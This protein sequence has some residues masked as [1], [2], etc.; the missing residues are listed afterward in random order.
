[1]FKNAQNTYIAGGSFSV[2]TH[3][4][5]VSTVNGPSLGALYKRVAPQAILNAGGRADEVRCHP[6]TRKEVIGRIEKWRDAQDTQTPSIF[7]L[8]GPAGAGKTAI[9]QT[10]GER[11]DAQEV[12]QANFF[13][14][15]TDA[16]RNNLSP[17]V[18]TLVHQIVLL[19]PEL[20][21]CMATV[22]VTNPLIL[23]SVL[24][25]QLMQLV[26]VPL[27][28]VRQSVSPYRPP[29]LL[30]D[31][32]DECEPEDKR[33]QRKIVHE[34]DK[35]LTKCPDLFR[36]M[37]ASRDE[38]QI[39]AAFNELSCQLVTLYLDDQYCPERDIRAFVNDK[40]KRVRNAHP[41]A[42]AL[43]V[44][45]PSVEDVEGIVKKSSGQFIY[46]ATVMRFIFDSSASPM[47]S[48]ARVQ[49]AAQ[50]S[51]NSKSPFYY[52]DRIYTY[53]LSQVEDQEALKDILHAQLLIVDYLE[54]SFRVFS[55]DVKLVDI[56]QPY[57]PKYTE[58]IFQSCLAD[59]SSIAHYAH[60]HELLFYHASFPDYLLDQSRS[61]GYF[62]DIDAF[63]FKIQPLVW[64]ACSQPKQRT[65][66][67]LQYIALE[68]LLRLRQPPSGFLN[69]LTVQDILFACNQPGSYQ[70]SPIGHFNHIHSLCVYDDDLTSYKR[71]LF[72]WI[73]TRPAEY[74]LFQDNPEQQPHDSE[75][76]P[77]SHRYLAMTY[78]A[79]HVTTKP[80]AWF[81]IALR[82]GA[83]LDIHETVDWLNIVL[84]RIHRKKYHSNIQEYKQLVQK[85][86]TWAA[87][88]DIPLNR[89]DNLPKARWY[90]G[91]G[92]IKKWVASHLKLGSRPE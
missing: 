74:L 10:I 31:G 87:W 30:I 79:D 90:F 17:L 54:P 5:N 39:R 92:K 77:C 37:V 58:G 4:T 48:L 42:H 88:N 12:P 47:L 89:L 35:V 7:W 64:K 85:W 43:D 91:R 56:L 44:T 23:D 66:S 52:L 62:V 50:I 2:T 69:T 70:L 40:F 25:D 53:I 46:A 33:S 3:N 20:R 29:L 75:W 21:D 73:R 36:L 32:L 9:M 51:G 76:P 59:L 27:Q 22:L 84:H 1:M 15:R 38:S 11:S 28:A 18:A 67:G 71:N 16:S 24:E 6:G 65:H 80:P 19:Y 13:F 68:G 72:Q 8:S 61:G 41:L 26:V 14:F 63:N 60:N 83:D 45:W 49:G 55:Q 86:M 81:D 82:R 78:I 34:F 57:N